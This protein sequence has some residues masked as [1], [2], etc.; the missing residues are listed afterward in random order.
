MF[1]VEQKF[2]LLVF[3]IEPP[4]RLLGGGLQISPA[5]AVR[6]TWPVSELRS[7]SSS[8]LLDDFAKYSPVFV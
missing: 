6:E 2:P 7:C 8:M 3:V 4:R 1:F 5:R